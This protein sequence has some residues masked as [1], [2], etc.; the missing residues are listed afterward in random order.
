MMYEKLSSD[1]DL[2]KSFFRRYLLL[3][4]KSINFNHLQDVIA[5]VWIRIRL[6]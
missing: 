1:P 4:K 6:I 2:K 3:S 5:K